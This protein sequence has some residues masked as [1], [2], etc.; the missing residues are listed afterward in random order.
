MTTWLRNRNRLLNFFHAAFHIGRGGWPTEDVPDV[1]VV[2]PL[3]PV[4]DTPP[5]PPVVPDVP[6]VIPDVPP[7]VPDVP[8][9]TATP[10]VQAS[11]Q[12]LTLQGQPWRFVADTAWW[13]DKCRNL[14][15]YLDTRQKQGFNTIIFSMDGDWFT[16]S[17]SR[18]DERRFAIL[19]RIRMEIASRGMFLILTP[20]L[21]QY[22]NGNPV[23]RLPRSEA[24]A[25]GAYYGTRYGASPA[26]AFW[27]VGGLD[28][29]G[30]VS[31]ADIAAIGTGIRGA[32]ANHLITYHPR[33][34]HSTAEVFPPSNIY[35]IA[36]YQSYHEY[37]PSAHDA[38]FRGMRAQGIP[39]ANIEGPFENDSG[40]PVEQVAAVGALA[41]KH[42]P[43]GYA[44]GH[45]DVW[46]MGRGWEDALN[47]P[48]LRAWLR[49]IR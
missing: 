43:C 21:H 44:Y 15:L 5:A 30:V 16:G 26:I 20:N 42:N 19:D 22:E 27:M 12:Q 9:V 4:P 40:V 23:L 29:K 6:V 39:F 38:A 36:L 37:L 2:P 13:L 28:D 8:P 46:T 10:Y 45:G 1:P 47:A 48:G 33:A 14:A 31:P 34:K 3:P 24:A 18:P 11:G 7:V 35:Q 41:R 25:F 32:D 17:V 49:A